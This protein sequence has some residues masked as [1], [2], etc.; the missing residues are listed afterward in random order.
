MSHH[1]MVNILTAVA[2]PT[3]VAT[4][5]QVVCPYLIETIHTGILARALLQLYQQDLLLVTGTKGPYAYDCRE[6]ITTCQQY[7]ALY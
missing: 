4:A 7:V 3:A 6:P 1:V 2:S 5:C